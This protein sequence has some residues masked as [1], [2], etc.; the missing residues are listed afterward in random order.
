MGISAHFS[1][2]FLPF[3]CGFGPFFLNHTP[4]QP[5]TT[6][7]LCYAGGEHGCL[8]TACLGKVGEA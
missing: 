7:I 3:S 8:H 4:P 2:I 1:P 6:H 5:S